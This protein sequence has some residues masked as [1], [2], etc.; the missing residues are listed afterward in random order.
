MR[1]QRRRVRQGKRDL[2]PDLARIVDDTQ[3]R[4]R[5]LL[6]A[7]RPHHVV[8]V[9]RLDEAASITGL[10][11][12]ASIGI[13]ERVR[14]IDRGDG[15]LVGGAGGPGRTVAQTLGWRYAESPHR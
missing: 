7:L 8:G 5:G 1:G 2:N 9:G 13:E 3:G 4:W 15:A 14:R 11:E 12:P 10:A 6:R